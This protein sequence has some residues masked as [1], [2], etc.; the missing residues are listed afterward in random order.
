MAGIAVA[1]GGEE[2]ENE[3]DVV[4]DAEGEEPSS[5]DE[6]LRLRAILSKLLRVPRRWRDRQYAKCGVCEWR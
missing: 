4:E 1:W 6:R 5:Q 3:E 2:K